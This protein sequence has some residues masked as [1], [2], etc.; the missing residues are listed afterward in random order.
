ML[1]EIDEWPNRL[2]VF[3]KAN[4]GHQLRREAYLIKKMIFGKISNNTH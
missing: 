1:T 3:S 2:K 4:G